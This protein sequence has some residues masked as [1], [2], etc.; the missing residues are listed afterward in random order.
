MRRRKSRANIIQTAS[1]KYPKNAV[2]LGQVFTIAWPL[3]LAIRFKKFGAAG[4]QR[5]PLVSCRQLSGEGG[6]ELTL[7]QLNSVLN[8][9]FPVVLRKDLEIYSCAGSVGWELFGA[10]NGGIVEVL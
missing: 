2:A 10:I 3:L 5:Q 1:P 4:G 8:S 6:W 9:S 7:N